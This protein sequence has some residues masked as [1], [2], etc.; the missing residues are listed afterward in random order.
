EILNIPIFVQPKHQ[1]SLFVKDF[2]GLLLFLGRRRRR[3]LVALVV[4]GRRGPQLVIEPHARDHA[5]QQTPG[6]LGLLGDVH[7]LLDRSQ[8]AHIG[9]GRRRRRGRRWGRY[10]GSCP[11]GLRDRLRGVVVP[12]LGEIPG[13]VVALGGLG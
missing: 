9:G 10:H 8:D 2:L 5:H 12:P 13:Q 4:L 3:R 11:D 1:S 6:F 7:N